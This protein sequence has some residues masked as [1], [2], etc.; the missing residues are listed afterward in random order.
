LK[1]IVTLNEFSSPSLPV[2]LT[3]NHVCL[4]GESI[5]PVYILHT[6]VLSGHVAQSSPGEAYCRSASH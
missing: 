3:I 2:P 5:V 1:I 4:Y 6:Q